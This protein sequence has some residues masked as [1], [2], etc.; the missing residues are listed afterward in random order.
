ME[1][2]VFNYFPHLTPVMRDRLRQLDP[3]YREWNEKINVISR[4]DMDNLYLHHVLHSLAIAKA[5]PFAP[6]ERVLDVGTGGG[7]PGVP[8]AILFPE[9]RFV[10]CDSIGK[11]IRVVEEVV[12]AL[13]L[14][15]VQAVKARAEELPGP[16][17]Y[18]VSRAVT[19]LR[20][21]L[22]WVE[23]KYTKGLLYLKGGDLSPEGALGRELAAALAACRIPA[24]S[25]TVTEVGCWFREEF[26]REKKVIFI[27]GNRTR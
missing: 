12:R 3:L 27:P 24:R 21:F 17:D 16:F 14:E 6:G 9:T 8:L 25:V 20:N 11:K 22:P 13:G 5:R 7:F 26:F 2:L 1:E 18:I 4:K 23:G 10:L 19:D 15:N